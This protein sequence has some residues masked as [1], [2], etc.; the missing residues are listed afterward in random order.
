MKNTS[1]LNTITVQETNSLDSPKRKNRKIIQDAIELD[2]PT[3]EYCQ[4]AV[5]GVELD[6]PM[7][8]ISNATT[9]TIEFKEESLT[10]ANVYPNLQPSETAEAIS[11]N[12]INQEKGKHSQINSF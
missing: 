3:R 8:T 6:R 2:T 11:A 9:D 1:A 4:T 5:D 12:Q 7:Q 10:R